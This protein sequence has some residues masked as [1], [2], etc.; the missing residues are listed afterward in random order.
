MAVVTM[1]EGLRDVGCSVIV[2]TSATRVVVVVE[3]V[4]TVDAPTNVSRT[5]TDSRLAEEIR[6]VG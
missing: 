1:S 4:S 2:S 5:L 6:N 3:S